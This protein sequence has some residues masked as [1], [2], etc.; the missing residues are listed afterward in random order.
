MTPTL[1]LVKTS[2]KSWKVLETVFSHLNINLVNSSSETP[3]S[4]ARHFE[5]KKKTTAGLAARLHASYAHDLPQG[6]GDLAPFSQEMNKLSTQ[7]W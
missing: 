1:S 4:F 5:F 2:L 7:T 6:E 3:E